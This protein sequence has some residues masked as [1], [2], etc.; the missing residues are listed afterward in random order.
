MC[1]GWRFRYACWDSTTSTIR[2]RCSAISTPCGTPIRW[3]RIPSLVLDS[4]ET[5]IDSAA[6][7]DWLDE[8][9][10]PERALLPRSGAE[11]RN[12]LRRI[13]LATGAIDKFG[14]ANYERLIRPSQFHWPE[15]TARCLTQ[16][17][18]A[19]AALEA[20]PWPADAPLDQP[21]IT[22]CCMLNYLKVTAPEYFSAQQF[23]ALDALWQRLERLPQFRATSFE[24]Y[25]VPRAN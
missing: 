15:W 23:P 24:G 25:A 11:R 13:A 8:Q 2:A 19:L 1:A 3:G 12:A 7:L 6:I 14:A 16:G 18:G 21:Q 17:N 10:A 9:V 20:L 4:G 5:L 22:A